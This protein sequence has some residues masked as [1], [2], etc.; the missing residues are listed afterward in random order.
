MVAKRGR[1]IKSSTRRYVIP[2]NTIMASIESSRPLRTYSSSKSGESGSGRFSTTCRRHQAEPGKGGSQRTSPSGGG[3][4]L[5]IG[6][7]CSTQKV[8]GVRPLYILWGVEVVFDAEPDL[9]QPREPRIVQCGLGTT[10]WAERALGRASLRQHGRHLLPPGL[11]LPHRKGR[12]IQ[13]IAVG[14]GQTADY[15]FAEAKCRVDNDLVPRA[16]HGIGGEQD[17]GHLRSHQPLD[18]HGDGNLVVAEPLALPVSDGTSRPE[19]TPAAA[20]R[21]EQFVLAAD[22]Q[23]GHLLAGEAGTG[24]VLFGCT[25]ADCRRWR[26]ERL[27]SG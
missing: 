12:T 16:G 22:V 27:V 20:H 18:Y 25:G 24:Q 13:G 21:V 10:L 7:V 8:V 2:K 1:S 9:G 15:R 23:R 11:P 4:R 26:A 5:V 17:A 14:G 3:G 19:R 6:R